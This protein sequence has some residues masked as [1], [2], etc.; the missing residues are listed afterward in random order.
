MF[1]VLADG[2]CRKRGGAI[3]CVWKES[4]TEPIHSV[5]LT[6]FFLFHIDP[7][8]MFSRTPLIVFPVNSMLFNTSNSQSEDEN[9]SKRLQIHNHAKYLLRETSDFIENFAKVHG[10]KRPRLPI[11]FVKSFNYLKKEAKKINFEDSFL[12]FLPNG[13]EMQLL[14]KYGP[15]EDFPKFVENGFL[16]DKKQTIVNDVAQFYTDIIQYVK[17]TYSVSKQIPVFP[18]SYFMTL[19]TFQ[20]RIGENSKINKRIVDE[21]PEQVQLGLKMYMGEVIENDFVDNCTDKYDENTCL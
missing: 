5:H 12:N 19:K 13:I 2:I 8:T 20:Q 11:F 18:Y 9:S 4:Q 17:D 21:I 10:E 16:E 1:Q 6:L 14:T 7:L 3:Q 15:S